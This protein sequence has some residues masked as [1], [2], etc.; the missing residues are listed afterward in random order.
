MEVV[1]LI[2]IRCWAERIYD[3]IKQ[4]GFFFNTKPKVAKEEFKKIGSYL[5]S[6]G[7]TRKELERVKEIFRSDIDE[8]QNYEQGIS[9]E[10]ID[11]GIQWMRT[12]PNVHHIPMQKIDILEKALK[13]KL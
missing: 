8:S 10:E 13:S 7:F 5:Y 11:K 4:M 2:E 6:I 9:N 1:S 3:I 12:N